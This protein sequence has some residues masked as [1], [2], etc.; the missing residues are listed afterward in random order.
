MA[1]PKF[2]TRERLLSALL[3]QRLPFIIALHLLITVT[4]FYLAVLLRYEFSLKMAFG[5]YE[6]HVALSILLLMR[7]GCYTYWGLNRGYWRYVSTHDLITLIKAHVFS[8]LL[9]TAAILLFRVPSFPRSVIIIELALSILFAGGARMLVRLLS[10]K[11]LRGEMSRSGTTQRQAIILGAGNTGHLLVKTL[12]AHPTIDYRPIAILD[13]SERLRGTS[14]YGVPVAGP[15]SV[16]ESV[17]ASERRVAAV[18]IAI[19]SLSHHRLQQIELATKRFSV[20]VKKLQS[21]EDIVCLDAAH[22]HDNLSIESVLEKEVNVEHEEAI[23][24]ELKGKRILI[25][26]AGG[27]IGSELVRQICAFEPTQV[28]LLDNSEFNLFSIDRELRESQSPIARRVALGSITDAVRLKQIFSDENPEI[29]FH[30]AAYKHVPLVECNAYESFRNNVIGT[31]NLLEAAI[32]ANARHFV[33][34]S[35]DKA[36]DP[37][38]LM[39]CSKRIA[40]LLVHSYTASKTSTTSAS[41]VRFGNVINSAGSVVPIFREQILAGGPVTVTHPEMDRYFMSIREAVRLVLTAGV[42]GER[43][44]VFVLDMGQKIR[45]VDLARKMLALYGRRDIPIVYTGLRPGEKLTEELLAATEKLAPTNFRRVQKVQALAQPPLDVARWV[46]ATEDMLASISEI[47]LATRMRSYIADQP[48]SQQSAHSQ[49]RSR[50]IHG[51]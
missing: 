23:R 44:E 39:G 46:A 34:I 5:R 33:L 47:D 42:L 48:Q 18:F 27:S 6:N 14:V 9:L 35:S 4:S 37:L 24:A 2:T 15:L 12:L 17:L 21:F 26:G 3:A 41:V 36:V 38:N 43:G 40:E 13:D 49:Q 10:E 16:L 25:T 31:R 11:L 45:I 19:P 7:F 28:T 20:P 50:V 30:A 22:P 8:A 51:I 32:A 1:D 29:V